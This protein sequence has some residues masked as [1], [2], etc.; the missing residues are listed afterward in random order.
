MGRDRG[1]RK[2]FT[3]IELLVVVAIIAL[4]IS[5]LLPSLNRARAQARTSICASRITQLAKAILMYA[6]DYDEV[7]PF[8]GR[9]W[10]DCDEL[11]DTEWPTGSG[12]TIRQWAYAE[13]WLMPNMPDYW[14][15]RQEIW[16]EYADVR[17][18]SLFKYTRFEGL[19]RCP[20]FERVSDPDKSQNAFNYTR[21]MLGRKW[22]DFSDPEADDGSPWRAAYGGPFGAPG[23]VLRIG[24]AYAPSRLYMLLDERWDRHCAGSDLGGPAGSGV[25]DGALSGMWLAI[26]SIWVI[27]DEGGHYHGSKKVSNTIPANL[28]HHITPIK[29]GNA[30]FFD[31]HVSLDTDFLPDRFISE[32]WGWDM[33][34]ATIAFYDWLKGMMF[35]QRGKADIVV[36][37]AL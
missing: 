9:G 25:L 17:D 2:A 16:P 29:A 7:P 10:E 28:A 20:D 27:G 31:G 24:Q 26:E 12:M 15:D 3:L 22:Y 33:V 30:A 5:I 37:V 6:D 18:G 14:F 32:D 8:L 21:S 34:L 35:T 19:Y 4:L 13:N 23:P 1:R 36:D 11:S